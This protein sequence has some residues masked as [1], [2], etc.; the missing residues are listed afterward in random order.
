MKDKT[1]ARASSLPLDVESRVAISI[2]K[3]AMPMDVADIN[4]IP[5]S[6]CRDALHRYCRRVNGEV[7]KA[8]DEEARKE[9]RKS[10]FLEKLR[11]KK[12]DF[13]PEDEMWMLKLPPEELERITAEK[14]E[15][16]KLMD[17]KFRRKRA[18]IEIMERRLM[19]LKKKYGID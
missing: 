14:R 1:K 4:D 13:L 11:R 7:Y 12:R 10:P 5:Y 9:G 17:I 15:S 6:V 8:L 2:L 19:K 16:F 3:G 18:S